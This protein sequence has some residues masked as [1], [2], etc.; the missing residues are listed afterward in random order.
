MNNETI[1]GEIIEAGAN[2]D[3]VPVVV[4]RVT[5]SQLADLTRHPIY[6]TAVVTIKHGDE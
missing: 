5:E 3:G 2:A 6:R 1:T 4:V